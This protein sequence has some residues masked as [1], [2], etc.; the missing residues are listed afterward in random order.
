M[1]DRV[2]VFSM[3]CLHGR[4]RCECCVYVCVQGVRRVWNVCMQ[5]GLV[6]VCVQCVCLSACKGF[7][8]VSVQGVE[9]TLDPH[10]RYEY[11][12]K[13]YVDP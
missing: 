8:C 11:R 4:V 2:C 7:S 3:F 12:Q 1:S 5:G 13:S 9:S 6:C 10:Q